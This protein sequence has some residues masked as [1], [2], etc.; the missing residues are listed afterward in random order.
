MSSTSDLFRL[1]GHLALVTGGGGGLGSAMAIAFADMGADLVL[2]ARSEG[3]LREVAQQVEARGRRA[4]IVPADITDPAA[5]DRLVAAAAGFGELSILVNNAGGLGGVDDKP[6]PLNALSE[7]SWAAQIELN[8][9]SVW[10]LTRA[11]APAIRNGGVIINISSIKSLKPEGGSGAYGASKAA[12]NNMTLALA[13]DLAPR[14]RVNA[15]APGPVP[16][17]AFMKARNVTEA[18]FPRVAAEWGVPLGR[19]G[20]PQDIAA[21]AVFLAAPAG[22]WITGQTIVVAGGM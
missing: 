19:V 11:A 9:T 21:A 4:L 14:I 12:M 8:L 5:A 3:K 22:S 17:E 7:D 1:D 16:T 20:S 6:L 15:I 13:H 18:D 10:R 2:T